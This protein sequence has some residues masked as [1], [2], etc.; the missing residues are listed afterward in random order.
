MAKKLKAMAEGKA[1]SRQLAAAVR[2]SAQQIWLAG[3][4]A[5]AKTQEEGTKVFEA[6][7]K[8]GTRLQ[9]Q[10]RAMTE[11]RIGEVTGKVTKA[12]SDITKQATQSWDKLEQVFED[13]VSRALTRLGVPTSKDIQDL[14]ARV[15]SLNDSVQ[16]LNGTAPAKPRRARKAPAAP[17]VRKPVRRGRAAKAA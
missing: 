11:E 12:A 2:D 15:E 8:E 9:R 14:I 4:G 7:V 3:L 6:L 1:E 16:A 17:A 5:F 13:R 10:T